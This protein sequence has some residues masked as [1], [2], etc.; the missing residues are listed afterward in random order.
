MLTNRAN[1]TSW[2]AVSYLISYVSVGA[3]QVLGA[4]NAYD[5]DL[6]CEYHY[7]LFKC[8]KSAQRTTDAEL[9]VLMSKRGKEE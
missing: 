6:L 2:L 4:L 1:K 8:F 7:R 3:E 5:K 9:C